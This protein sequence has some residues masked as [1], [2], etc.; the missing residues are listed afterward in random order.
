MA[1]TTP[2]I[3]EFAR[4]FLNCPTV[5]GIPLENDGGNGSLGA[6]WERMVLFNEVMTAST[7]KDSVFSGFTASLIADSG[8]YG[9]DKN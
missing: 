4:N 5:D 2:K 7:I 3:L 9:F 1:L 8:W 6:H